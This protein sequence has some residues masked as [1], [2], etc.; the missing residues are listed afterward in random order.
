MKP[1]RVLFLYN[2]DI[3][4]P[5]LRKAVER[6]SRRMEATLGFG[7][8]ASYARHDFKPPFV[9]Y[10]REGR[11]EKWIPVSWMRENVGPL[12]SG[13]H[14]AFLCLSPGRWPGDNWLKGYVE[15]SPY[16]GK[17]YLAHIVAAKG[18]ARSDNRA[19][20]TE[21]SIYH[22]TLHT[23]EA[24]TGNFG[25]VHRSV[26]DLDAAAR[27]I[28]KALDRTASLSTTIAMLKAQLSKLLSR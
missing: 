18:W 23:F 11:V 20:L 26:S 8:E 2:R 12:T 3:S 27:E 25:I 22:E 14:A 5:W 17:T 16:N 9:R 7:I 21:D 15:Y 13:E 28:R 6:V 1:V 24:E 4:K 10:D 19:D